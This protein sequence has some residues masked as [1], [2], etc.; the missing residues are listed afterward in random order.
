M[1]HKGTKRRGRG[2]GSI[3]QRADG[4]WVGQVDAGYYL[5]GRRR[6]ARVVRAK[7]VQVVAALDELRRQ[8]ADGFVPDRTRTVE[9]YLTFWLDDVAADTV[10][11]SSLAEYRKRVKRVNDRIGQLRLGKLSTAH[12]QRLANDLAATYSA[13]TA[14]TTMET[15]R[16][17]LRWAH[18][19]GLIVRNPA[20]GVKV[21]GT[22][23][24]KIDDTL[25][26]AE[27]EAVLAAAEGDLHAM[28]QLALVY[29]LRIGEILDL[30]WSDVDLRSGEL[31]VRK[32]KT[33]AGERTLPLLD[34]T[35][36]ALRAQRAR[37]PM[38]GPDAYVFPGET[39]GRLSPQN[40][41]RRWS[42]LLAVAGVEHR[43]TSC[44][45][46]RTCSTSVRRFHS[47]R[48]TAATLMLER[49]VDLEVVSAILG[50]A[51]LGITSD[52]YARVRADAKRRA[53]AKGSVS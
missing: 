51:N 10:S 37:T 53:L 40:T 15:L 44:G 19:G 42:D 6:Y 7:R 33:R 39:G 48:H 49:G 4:Y 50:H 11:E 28:A 3:Y 31:T 32:A 27:A 35:A 18:H 8:I 1:T 43:C 16:S 22:V 47:S 26:A 5:N 23:Q 41:R 9:R 25:T 38:R 21:R 14:R 34:D 24:A 29:G 36:A 13:K 46:E 12:C 52:T 30:R 45:T 20:E 2:E 17:A